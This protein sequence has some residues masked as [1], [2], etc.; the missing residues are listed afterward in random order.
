M[1]SN[2]RPPVDYLRREAAALQTAICIGC[3]CSEFE[4][5]ISDTLETCTWVE[6]ELGPLCSFCAEMAAQM[7][8]CADN[9][10]LVGEPEPADE[11]S[12]LVQLASDAD[13]DAFLRARRA[14]A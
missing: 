4:P 10:L 13:C 12:P 1:N 2:F 9:L 14:V 6:C 5:C 8:D 7:Y 3:G 11:L